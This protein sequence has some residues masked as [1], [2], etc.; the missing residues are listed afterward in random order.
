M[1]AMGATG[2]VGSL[3]GF[4][5]AYTTSMAPME[6]VVEAVASTNTSASAGAER[7]SPFTS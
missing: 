7:R 4:T 2:S 3:G 1:G 6:A 5:P